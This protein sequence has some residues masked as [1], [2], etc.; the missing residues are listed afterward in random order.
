MRKSNMRK[1]KTIE[2]LILPGVEGERILEPEVECELMEFME[3]FNQ[4]RMIEEA[5]AIEEVRKTFIW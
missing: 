4:R 2:D 1:F 3:E 5:K